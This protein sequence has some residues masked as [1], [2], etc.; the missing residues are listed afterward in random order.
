MTP[1]TWKVAHN[2]P[3]TFFLYTGPAAQTAQKQKSST[4]KSPLMQDWVFRMGM[5]GNYLPN[6]LVEFKLNG[7]TVLSK[8]KVK[9]CQNVW[10]QNG[11]NVNKQPQRIYLLPYNPRFLT[12]IVN[13]ANNYQ[14]NSSICIHQFKNYRWFLIFHFVLC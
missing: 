12:Q 1:K 7:Q 2:Q 3:P 4:T 9:L 14:I 10:F 5:Y 11:T 8:Y 6:W 13:R